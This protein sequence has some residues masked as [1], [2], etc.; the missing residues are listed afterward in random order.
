MHFHEENIFMRTYA[1]MIREI[2]WNLKLN[3]Y[4]VT[5]A[6]TLK[7]IQTVAKVLI[8]LLQSHQCAV[9]RQKETPKITQ[10]LD[11]TDKEQYW[12]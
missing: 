3:R 6:E 8:F 9:I 12:K 1:G 5:K 10:E 2:M 7:Q 4:I 11:K